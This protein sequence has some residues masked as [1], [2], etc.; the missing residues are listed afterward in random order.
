MKRVLDDLLPWASSEAATRAGC[1]GHPAFRLSKKV[2]QPV[3]SGLLKS[4]NDGD[5]CTAHPISG[6]GFLAYAI[7]N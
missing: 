7:G 2:R 1:H 5:P 3:L 4:P 6:P